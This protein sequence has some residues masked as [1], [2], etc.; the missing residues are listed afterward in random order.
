MKRAYLRQHLSLWI[1][2]AILT[3]FALFALFPRV[4]SMYDVKQLFEPWQKPSTQHLLGTNDMGYDV[5]SELVT[6]TATTIAVALSS[7]LLST[8][9]GVAIGVVAGSKSKVVSTVFSG[10]IDVFLAVP[11]LPLMVVLAAFLPKNNV[12]TALLIAMLSWV[13]TARLI[14]VNT[15]EIL[16]APYITQLYV[17]GVDRSS[18]YLRHIVPNLSRVVLSRLIVAT[19]SAV[20]TQSTLGFLGLTDLTQ[21]TWGSMINFAYKRG[22]FLRE[23]Y[24]WLLSPAICI[25]LLA[26]AFSLIGRYIEAR[27]KRVMDNNG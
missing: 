25:A 15:Q 18:I 23:A 4:F 12:T 14:K 6:A 10:L 17:L 3:V 16:S 9:L 20:L 21:P 26:L 2:L 7:A 1:A 27:N 11:K 19:S 13:T 22:G 8:A 24:G 5:W